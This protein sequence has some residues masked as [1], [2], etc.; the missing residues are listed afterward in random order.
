MT[1]MTKCTVCILLFALLAVVVVQSREIKR[2][3]QW[4]R[5]ANI[6]KR[7]FLDRCRDDNDCCPNYECW[8][9]PV[10]CIPPRGNIRGFCFREQVQCT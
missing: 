2:A 5:E 6:E 8:V 4:Y 7:C 1:F 10:T 3:D 9:V